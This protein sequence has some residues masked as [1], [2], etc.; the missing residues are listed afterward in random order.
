ME[1]IS[2]QCRFDGRMIAL[3]TYSMCSLNR[4]LQI[5]AAFIS[6]ARM[7]TAMYRL[8]RVPREF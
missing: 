1:N 8:S 2:W 4:F 3:D 5:L 6:L 7:M